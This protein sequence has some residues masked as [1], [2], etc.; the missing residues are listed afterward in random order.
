MLY[1]FILHFT[2]LYCFSK[3]KLNKSFKNT[4][5]YVIRVGK[6]LARKIFNVI[7]ISLSKATP[8]KNTIKKKQF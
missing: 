1:L 7:Y 4:Q 5:N 8:N 6:G 3:K 2:T